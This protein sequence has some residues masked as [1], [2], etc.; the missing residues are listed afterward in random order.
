MSFLRTNALRLAWAVA[1]MATFGSL[2]FQ[3]VM[4]L[5]PCVLCWFQRIAMYPL[6]ILIGLALKWKNEHLKAYLLPF[7]F[8]GGAIAFY[9]NLFYYKILPE[10]I[11]PC[12]AG[13]SCTTKLIEWGGFI[14]I[15]LLSLAGFIAI[16]VLIFLHRESSAT[17]PSSTS[18]VS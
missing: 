6:V 12:Q 17:Q 14:T 15:P 10:S 3:Y 4:D 9:H 11:A 8:I 2:Y 5:P 7:T 1:V 16:T 13:V 18:S